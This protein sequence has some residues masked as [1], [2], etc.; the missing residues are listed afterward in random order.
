MRHA[1][2]AVQLAWRSLTA[3]TA[4]PVSG[5]DE[6]QQ[7]RDDDD[8]AA[9]HAA[10]Q[11]LVN[12]LRAMDTLCGRKELIRACSLLIQQMAESGPVARRLGHLFSSHLMATVLLMDAVPVPGPLTGVAE[13]SPHSLGRVHSSCSE[14]PRLSIQA[15]GNAIAALLANAV[16]SLID[17]HDHKGGARAI[18]GR[19]RDD[20]GSPS[21]PC[22]KEVA[23]NRDPDGATVL[24]AAV[25]LSPPELVSVAMGCGGS[26]QSLDN[27]ARPAVTFTERALVGDAMVADG[28]MQVNQYRF[29]RVLGR[30]SQGSVFLAYDAEQMTEV[31]V[32]VIARPVHLVGSASTALRSRLR[33]LD[34][35]ELLRREILIMKECRHKNIMALYEVIDDEDHE[36][37]YLVLQHA[38][39]GPIVKVDA[40]GDASRTLGAAEV[41]SVGRQLCAGLAYLHRHSIAH[42]DIKPE[43]IL[44][45]GDGTPLLC[46]F[47]VSRLFK[48]GGGEVQHRTSLGCTFAFQPPEAMLKLIDDEASQSHDCASLNGE[49]MKQ[50]EG[51][52]KAQLVSEEADIWALGLSLYVMLCGQLPYLHHD[53]NP[54]D[55][56]HRYAVAVATMD[57][58]YAS[59]PDPSH[60]GPGGGAALTL[61]VV[62]VLKRMLQ[63]N[64]EDRCTAKDRSAACRPSV[65]S[66]NLPRPSMRSRCSASSIP[67]SLSAPFNPYCRRLPR[68]LSPSPSCRR[69]RAALELNAV[70]TRPLFGCSRSSI[71]KTAVLWIVIHA[72]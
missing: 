1:Q 64:P 67:P 68:P 7:H 15:D 47:G 21:R 57:L 40:N 19:Q 31:A 29:L 5:G 65:S 56:F 72:S 35:L 25:V 59:R 2:Q 3:V 42:C 8:I 33:K 23:L 30:G 44:V 66:R 70:W 16:P 45:G 22:D 46:D 55:R 36:E 52:S 32:K 60:G 18:R 24:L 6:Q 37:I 54:Q 41:A 63:R 38:Q 26:E 20:D 27:S 49:S 39:R 10:H 9:A 43:N 48:E 34:R 12:G 61:G 14:L 28:I 50:G 69:L 53:G 62:G 51:D 4:G 17:P 11:Q 13:A 58:D 71:P